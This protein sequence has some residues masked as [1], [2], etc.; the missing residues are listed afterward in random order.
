MKIKT[1]LPLLVSGANE[2]QTS[3]TK[4][5]VYQRILVIVQKVC[6]QL[7]LA[8]E[9]NAAR[10]AG[11]YPEENCVQIKVTPKLG[12]DFSLNLYLFQFFSCWSNHKR[13]G[14]IIEVNIKNDDLEEEIIRIIKE[15]LV[16]QVD[17]YR[18]GFA[19]EAYLFQLMQEMVDRRDIVRVQKAGEHDDIKGVDFIFRSHDWQGKI[20]DIPL[21]VKT[22]ARG[23]G[24]HQKKFRDVPSLM[25]L[26]STELE[27]TRRKVLEIAK[28][29]GA[30]QSK[31]LHL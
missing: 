17:A 22:S 15:S 26:V 31:A 24:E 20:F 8:K 4:F 18:V 3:K 30:K 7:L 1:V 19:A 12:N 11:I 27:E 14:R 29:Y 5:A 9:I 13:S 6:M 10:L 23:Q 28:A 21:Q 2:V 16:S 25:V